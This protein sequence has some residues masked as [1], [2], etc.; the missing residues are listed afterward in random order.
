MHGCLRTISRDKRW[1]IVPLIGLQAQADEKKT[2][3]RQQRHAFVPRQGK[4]MLEAV[5]PCGHGHSNC[6]VTKEDHR[7][8]IDTASALFVT[9]PSPFIRSFFTA[10]R[11]SDLT[12]ALLASYLGLI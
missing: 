9:S 1:G 12:Q 4:T 8:R 7:A 5:Q 3:E 10:N 6:G 11:K 2:S